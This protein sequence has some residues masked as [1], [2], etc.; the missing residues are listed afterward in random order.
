MPTLT[1]TEEEMRA[2]QNLY[3]ARPKVDWAAYDRAKRKILAVAL[4]SGEDA[5]PVVRACGTGEALHR[6][7][8][9]S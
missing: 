3:L 5:R 1:F 6:E 2:F 8:T 9:P 7:G 4:P